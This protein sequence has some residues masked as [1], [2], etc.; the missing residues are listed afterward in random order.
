MTGGS[1][2][3]WGMTGWGMTGG[4]TKRHMSAHMTPLT[5]PWV[6]GHSVT[7]THDPVLPQAVRTHTS[8]A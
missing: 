3:G 8:F 1:M 4:G 6:H 2:T 7:K 5:T